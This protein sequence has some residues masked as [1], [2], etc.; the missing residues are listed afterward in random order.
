MT[1]PDVDSLGVEGRTAILAGNGKLP[2][3]IAA[4]LV[5][6]NASPYVIAVT[7]DVGSWV[8]NHDHARILVTHLS[9]IIHALKAARVRNVVLAGGIRVRPNLSSFKLDWMTLKLLPLLFR[10][11]R[12]GDDGLLTAAVKWLESYGFSVVGSHQLVPSLLAPSGNLTLLVPAGQDEADM[13]LAIA[14]AHRLGRADIGQAAVT[15]AGKVIAVEDRQGTQA[16]L[17]RLAASQKGFS[18]VGILAKF[19]KPQQETRVDLPAI[20]PDTVDQVAAA[21]LAGIVVEAGKSLILDRELTIAR[22]NELG[23]FIVG[24]RG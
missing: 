11:L 18:R 12:K 10:S 1:T 13:K 19:A 22:A 24:M 8:D 2:E 7:S 4:Q 15:R 5:V 3:L 20:G 9:S 16:M 6:Q 23:I 14:E 17:A 21:G